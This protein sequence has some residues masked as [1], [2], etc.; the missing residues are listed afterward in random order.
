V[1]VQQVV[2]QGFTLSVFPLQQ[3]QQ[4]PASDVA[5]PSYNSPAQ[6]AA[7]CDRRQRQPLWPWVDVMIIIFCEKIRVFLKNQC[8][9]QNF[10]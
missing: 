5:K 1:V 9:D 8:Y 7:R 6:S 2:P 10:G 4:Q 3:Q